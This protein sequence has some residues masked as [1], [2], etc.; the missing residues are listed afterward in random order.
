M[1]D[2]KILWFISQIQQKAVV[3]A[4]VPLP[5]KN[6]HLSPTVKVVCYSPVWGIFEFEANAEKGFQRGDIIKL[7]KQPFDQGYT[8]LENETLSKIERRALAK[9]KARGKGQAVV[10]AVVPLPSTNANQEQYIKVICHGPKCGEIEIKAPATEGIQRGDIIDVWQT[11]N[12][13]TQTEYYHYQIVGNETL[14]KIKDHAFARILSE[15]TEEE[16]RKIRFFANRQRRT[17]SQNTK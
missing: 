11:K 12:T 6:E 13:I 2:D 17:R 14:S 1:R 5:N 16:R 8:L 10:R 4:V 3:R 15:F 7:A 9:I